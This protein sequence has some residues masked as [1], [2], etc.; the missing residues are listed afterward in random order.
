MRS[1]SN[2]ASVQALLLIVAYQQNSQ[3]SV[4]SW[5]THAWAV[6][7]A[8]QHGLQSHSVRQR[9][10]K[11]NAELMQRL[12]TGIVFNDGYYLSRYS[13]RSAFMCIC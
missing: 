11:S 12:W 3:R 8:L 4:S 13:S 1:V 6:K 7:A 5:T 2:P 9:Q 10:S